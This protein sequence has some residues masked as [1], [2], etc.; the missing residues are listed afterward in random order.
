M[1]CRGA[2]L[3]GGHFLPLHGFVSM[4]LDLGLVLD[5]LAIDLVGQKVDGSV[6]IFIA[7]FAVDVLAGKADGHFGGMLKLLDGEHDLRVDDVVEVATDTCHL[8]DGVF[9]DGGCDFQM[10]T[11]DAQV[12]KTLLQLGMVA[13]H[14]PMCTGWRPPCC[15]FVMVSVYI[16]GPLNQAAR[17]G[18]MTSIKGSAVGCFRVAVKELKCRVMPAAL[19]P[20]RPR[21]L[22]RSGPPRPR[23]AV[24]VV[25]ALPK[26][27]RIPHKH[28][29]FG[30]DRIVGTPSLRF[31][32]GSFRA[33]P[34]DTVTP[35]QFLVEIGVC[36]A[37]LHEQLLYS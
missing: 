17:V 12:H 13:R 1:V 14:A 6:E 34:G 28:W 2:G 15:G 3:F 32:D 36:R 9:A 21:F 19:R 22:A 33:V 5:D 11:T 26:N 23:L 7:R 25:A 31:N 27:L 35:L 29:R 18:G 24:S 30:L 8:V 16:F 4:V 10:T 20:R 37:T